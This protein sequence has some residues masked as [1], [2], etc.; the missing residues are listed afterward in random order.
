[1]AHEHI[2]FLPLNHPPRTEARCLLCEGKGSRR[3]A[4]TRTGDTSLSPLGRG[5]EFQESWKKMGPVVSEQGA[6][7]DYLQLDKDMG[8]G[9]GER[10]RTQRAA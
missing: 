1:M 7:S 4:W 8:L 3:G 9:K 10:A 5:V 6:G 2:R